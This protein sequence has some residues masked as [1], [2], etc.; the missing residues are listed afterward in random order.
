MKSD[1]KSDLHV[2]EL[3]D[4]DIRRSPT[5]SNMRSPSRIPKPGRYAVAA[6]ISRLRRFDGWHLQ[7]RATA[8]SSRESKTRRQRRESVATQRQLRHHAYNTSERRTHGAFLY[9]QQQQQQQLK[10]WLEW[11]PPHGRD[12]LQEH[13]HRITQRCWPGAAA[14]NA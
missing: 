7:G 12:A 5:I 3:R 13:Q 10:Q 1:L 9:Q 4:E 2:S 6:H 8:A 14:V 11:T